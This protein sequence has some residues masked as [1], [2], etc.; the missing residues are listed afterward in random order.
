MVLVLLVEHGSNSHDNQ[1]YCVPCSAKSGKAEPIPRS[2]LTTYLNDAA[3]HAFGK[4]HHSS[5]FEVKKI[6]S[7]AEL[8]AELQVCAKVAETT[9]RQDHVADRMHSMF[10]SHSDGIAEAAG[11][12]DDASLY[13]S[14]IRRIPDEK[15][16]R[17]FRSHVKALGKCIKDARIHAAYLERR[18][19]ELWVS[20]GTGLREKE[21]GP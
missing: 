20:D 8:E 2:G 10:S 14:F 12:M 5:S 11:N 17:E 4:E 7:V 21:V 13:E 6:G 16:R 1:F 19:G 3:H 15:D 9:G 18:V